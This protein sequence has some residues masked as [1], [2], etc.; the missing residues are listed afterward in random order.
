MEFQ[1]TRHAQSCNNIIEGIS[2]VYKKDFEPGLTSKGIE[3]TLKFSDKNE[4]SFGSKIV[5][6]SNL[7]RTWMTAVIL[8][9]K[10]GER[11]PDS[12][13]DGS[14][15]SSADGG[16]D[17]SAVSSADGGADGRFGVSPGG[18]GGGGGGGAAH[19]DWRGVG[20]GELGD[21]CS[22][23]G[24]GLNLLISPYLKE[25]K[26]H[27]FKKGNYP[28]KFEENIKKFVKFLKI[29]RINI[30]VV[31]WLPV[32]VELKVSNGYFNNESGYCNLSVGD[33]V[34]GFRE[35]NDTWWYGK[36]KG[37]VGKFPGWGYVKAKKAYVPPPSL[38]Q[39]AIY[40][41]KKKIKYKGFNWWGVCINLDCDNI[42]II[43]NNSEKLN[44]IILK[45]GIYLND[46]DL[47]T[48][49]GW[50]SE[51]DRQAAISSIQSANAR[52]DDVIHVVTHSRVMNEFLKKK[53][54]V[55]L[56]NENK[57]YSQNQQRAIK[58]IRNSNCWRFSTTEECDGDLTIYNGVTVDKKDSLQ[59]EKIC[60][61][62]L[63]GNKAKNLFVPITGHP[64]HPATLLERRFSSWSGHPSHTAP[65]LV[66]GHRNNQRFEKMTGRPIGR[67]N[68]SLL[69]GG[70]RRLSRKKK[71]K[72]NRFSQKKKL[73]NNI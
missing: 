64:S 5:F 61:N 25:K 16:A 57:Y 28:I 38:L 42:D 24:T 62:S 35:Y 36:S 43:E 8:Y 3:E 15:V 27:G 10:K 11:G 51:D 49:M 72:K 66:H 4:S 32:C 29:V 53:Y 1:F 69:I 6:V 2:S 50:I 58:E 67:D 70:S 60:Q 26:K 19:S 54:K 33:T 73:K 55:D 46:G 30:P 37:K 44:S 13:A 18:G 71:R 7:I 39:S 52:I 48:F 45:A 21:F 20:T 59:R 31:L 40:I 12:G 63:C 22:V 56:R 23:G 34:E 14:A 17:G 47:E 41:L 9:T 65:A 68:V